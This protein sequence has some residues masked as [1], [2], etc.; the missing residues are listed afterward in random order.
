MSKE[1]GQGSSNELGLRLINDTV[2]GK[3]NR[4]RSKD[5]GSEDG[6]SKGFSELMK[7]VIM[8]TEPPFAISVEGDWGSGKTTLIRG[9]L[10]GI[11]EDSLKSIEI[12]AWH[13]S[14]SGLKEDVDQ[15]VLHEIFVELLKE[16][17]ENYSI[18]RWCL[19]VAIGAVIISVVF[20]GK[21]SVVISVSKFEMIEYVATYGINYIVNTLFLTV[22]V[23]MSVSVLLKPS[24]LAGAHKARAHKASFIL[25]KR[26]WVIAA[27]TVLSAN[28]LN[29]VFTTS[30]RYD[31][32]WLQEIP[33]WSL[34]IA[35]IGALGMIL[36][37]N[38]SSVVFFANDVG[39]KKWN[40]VENRRL[41]IKGILERYYKENEKIV[42]FIDNLDRI[43]PEKALDVIEMVSNFMLDRRLFFIM[44]VDTKVMKS[45]LKERLNIT[46]DRDSEEFFHKIFQYNFKMPINKYEPNVLI[47]EMLNLTYRKEE[48]KE[49]TALKIFIKKEEGLQVEEKIKKLIKYSVGNNPRDIKRLL[50][51]YFVEVMEAHKTWEWSGDLKKEEWTKTE[52]FYFIVFINIIL[53]KF[54]RFYTML[55]HIRS[56]G[57]HI[58]LR[59]L[60]TFTSAENI[61]Q[62]FIN[63]EIE[64]MPYQ[65]IVEVANFME[66]YLYNLEFL[67]REIEKENIRVE[68]ILDLIWKN[69]H[70]IYT[71]KSLASSVPQAYLLHHD[72]I[73][74]Y[75]G[76]IYRESKNNLDGLAVNLIYRWTKSYKGNVSDIVE[77][78]NEIR[79]Y[80]KDVRKGKL[81]VSYHKN[82]HKDLS[83]HER[84]YYKEAV[85]NH[86]RDLG[87]NGEI[88]ILKGWRAEEIDQLIK[89]GEEIEHLIKLKKE[90]DEV[91]VEDNKVYRIPPK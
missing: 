80:Y 26:R 81:R 25:V 27:F 36:I 73:F 87:E 49:I 43:A 1:K 16:K 35:V 45:T 89:L 91:L 77:K 42:I 74:K 71:Q 14:Q 41:K 67:K 11:K 55:L 32:L 66:Q 10:N 8:G 44:A 29:V 63:H 3:K 20:L 6:V 68:D 76:H 18:V 21:N 65:A 75:G 60:W 9:V 72:Q 62:L 83:D 38:F 70:S 88:W 56:Y 51:N 19:G 57:Y 64:D 69:D 2:I 90:N 48:L 22:L 79:F 84:A 15:I 5:E 7:S 61:R 4:D 13:S 39:R 47:K 78:I 37:S 34:T 50:N 59:Y 33:G 28:A 86:K 40:N 23:G 31:S 85:P 12:D 24:R 58:D 53:R 82:E 54:E 46:S 30:T 17:G 52:E